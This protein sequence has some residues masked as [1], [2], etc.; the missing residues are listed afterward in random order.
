MSG[1]FPH[2]CTDQ[3]RVKMGYPSKSWHVKA[4]PERK[5]EK[6]WVE[7]GGR[8]GW[9]GNKNIPTQ[10]HLHTHTMTTILEST[11]TRTYLAKRRDHRV[12]CSPLGIH[13]VVY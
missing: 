12:L 8:F 11:H 2:T 9:G 3:A 6:W 4:E 10:L 5:G 13:P 1:T 7:L